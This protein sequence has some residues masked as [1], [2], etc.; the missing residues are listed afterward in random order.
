MGLMVSDE[1]TDAKD[2]KAK[3][4]PYTLDKKRVERTYVQQ[5]I[6]DELKREGLT[7][8]QNVSS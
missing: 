8:P 4:I 1:A 7:I 3:A 2:G 6:V 5:D